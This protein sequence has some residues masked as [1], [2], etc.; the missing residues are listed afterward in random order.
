MTLTTH[1]HDVLLSP[2]GIAQSAIGWQSNPVD[3]DSVKAGTFRIEC[4]IGE[5]K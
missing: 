2:A 3:S 1:I 5:Q 4:W